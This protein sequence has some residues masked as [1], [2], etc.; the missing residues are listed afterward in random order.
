MESFLTW[1]LDCTAKNCRHL[2]ARP[3]S[4]RYFLSSWIINSFELIKR[5]Y[6]VTKETR[7]CEMNVP[8]FLRLYT[9]CGPYCTRRAWRATLKICWTKGRHTLCIIEICTNNIVNVCRMVV[10]AKVLSGAGNN[11][12]AKGLNRMLVLCYS[13]AIKRTAI[14]AG[15]FNLHD[16]AVC[17][18]VGMHTFS[19]P[20]RAR[21]ADQ[22]N[23]ARYR[24]IELREIQLL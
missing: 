15:T 22:E 8:L 21:F 6:V 24:G 5:K 20:H 10:K 3:R 18:F 2:H 13:S 1:T 19:S 11:S 4:V 16:N 14:T 23:I 7:T 12:G 9:R 17:S